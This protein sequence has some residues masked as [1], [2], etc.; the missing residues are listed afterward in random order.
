MTTSYNSFFQYGCII[1]IF[2]AVVA[3]LMFVAIPVAG[4]DTCADHTGQCGDDLSW[5]YDES[6]RI[7]TIT[8]TG[9]MFDYS[10]E[11]GPWHCYSEHIAAVAL[12]EGLTYIGSNAFIRFTAL[13]SVSIPGTVTSIGEGAFSSCSSLSSVLIFGEVETVGKY[14]FE[15]C[16]SLTRLYNCTDGKISPEQYGMPQD[17]TV[18]I[19]KCGADLTWKLTDNGRTLEIAGFGTMYD[20]SGI[21]MPW[22]CDSAYIAKIVL[23]EGLTSIGDFAFYKFYALESVIIPNAVG[24]IGYGAFYE[25]SSLVSAILPDSL[26][27]L[28]DY[29]F[30]CCYSLESVDLPDSRE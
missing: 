15:E 23:P 26:K 14:A 25:C 22:Y 27:T 1:S 29:S 12:P 20:Y 4:D 30:M 7:L 24:S 6:D 5:D 17:V 8:G 18:V 28:G 11:G 13:D 16:G 19:G 21:D 3:V 2:A 10:W 9:K